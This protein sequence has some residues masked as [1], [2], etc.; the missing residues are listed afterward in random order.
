MERM[1]T[2]ANREADR[3]EARKR[4]IDQVD[5]PE[6]GGTDIHQPIGTAMK[7][8]LLVMIG[9]T[10]L[11]SACDSG[12]AVDPDTSLRTEATL[13]LDVAPAAPLSDGVVMNK[14]SMPIAGKATGSGHFYWAPVN[15][16]EEPHLRTF[17]INAIQTVGNEA[18]GSFTLGHHT[19]AIKSLR[20]GNHPLPTLTGDVGCAI[21]VY[22]QAEIVGTFDDG[23]PF[24]V[25]MIDGKHE[26]NPDMLTLVYYGPWVA[27][28]G[29][30]AV[31][32]GDRPSSMWWDEFGRDLTQE[33]M[34]VERGNINVWDY[35][36]PN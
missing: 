5:L 9:C 10:V 1:G 24:Y 14:G 27:N 35:T 4:I 21:F 36:D 12:V 6:G 8:L 20:D 31:C 28:R 25:Y 2:D 17:T 22:D 29:Y 15:S 34:Q 13:S 11:L 19:Q 3:C 16:G 30:D 33:M 23:T 7:H 32:N 26:G 18:R